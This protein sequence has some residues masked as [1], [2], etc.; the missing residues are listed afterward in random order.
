MEV[1]V[2][3]GEGRPIISV[4]WLSSRL[5]SKTPPIPLSCPFPNP[6][7]SSD[8]TDTT[9][10]FIYGSQAIRRGSIFHLFSQAYH[11]QLYF[12][13]G[14]INMCTIDTYVW[15]LRREPQD[16]WGKL[17]KQCCTYN[18]PS[19]KLGS[20]LFPESFLPLPIP[21]LK[22]EK[23]FNRQRTFRGNQTGKQSGD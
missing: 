12:I 16:I 7:C 10:C 11:S 1:G 15:K 4:F 6:F 18:I 8:T 5:G 17:S 14:L 19:I 3:G 23:G 20:K 9:R 13:I 22:M 21:G 2:G